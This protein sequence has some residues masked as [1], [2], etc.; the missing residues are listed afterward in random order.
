MVGDDGTIVAVLDWEIC[1]LGDPLADVGLLMVYWT[2][3]ER[4]DAGAAAAAPPRSR[5]SRAAPSCWSATPRRPAATC[6]DIDYYVAFGYWKLACILEGVYARYIGG[7]MGDDGDADDFD[8]FGE[9]VVALVEPARR[10]PIGRLRH[11]PRSYEL[12]RAPRRSTSPVL[13]VVLDGWIDAGLGAAA[14]LDDRCLDTGSTRARSPRSTPTSCSTT[15]PAGP[16]MHLVDGVKTGLTWPTIELRAGSRPRR[17]RRAVPR[18]RRA[19]PLP[20]GRFS[21]AVVDLAV[22]LGCRMVVGLGRLSRRRCPT[23]ARRAVVATAATASWPSRS[24]SSAARVDVPAGV[25]AAIERAAA[26][27]SACRPSGCGPRCPTTRRPCPTRPRAPPCIEAL[28]RVA[29]LHFGTGDLARRRR[30][31]PARG[32]T[33]SSPTATSTSSWSASSR[34][35]STRWPSDRRPVPCPRA[36]SWPPSSSV[37]ARPGRPLTARPP[38][39]VPSSAS[40]DG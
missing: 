28:D 31:P 34:S 12:R 3:A 2:D 13:V 30:R 6:R 35:R 33:R 40:A 10:R 1:T 23:P 32:S 7:A 39:A 24:A 37:P 11:E 20:G 9:Q 18:R 8:F 17:Q 16:T 29:G 5:A 21:E 14:A 27:R 38:G 4:P 36:R 25:Q 22:E 26:P 19:R 15:G